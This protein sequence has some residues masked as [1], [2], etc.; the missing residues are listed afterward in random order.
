MTTILEVKNL[1]KKYGDFTAVNGISFGV[2]RGEIFSL[3]GPNSAG[4]TTTISLLSTVMPDGQPQTTS[5]WRNH[6]LH[7]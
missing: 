4:K 2:K 7:Y 1:F 6:N 3:L 5:V